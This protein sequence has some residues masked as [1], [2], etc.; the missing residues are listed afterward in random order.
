MRSKPKPGAKPAGA[1][2]WFRVYKLLERDF[3]RVAA[4]RRICSYVLALF[5]P[6]GQE[7]QPPLRENRGVASVF[8]GLVLLD[9]VFAP[10]RLR[11]TRATRVAW[12]L[13]RRIRQPTSREEQ[14]RVRLRDACVRSARGVRTDG[15]GGP[16]SV[17]TA[18]A[19]PPP[20][21]RIARNA[22]VAGRP[23]ELVLVVSGLFVSK[24]SALAFE[25]AWQRPHA[26]RHVARDWN[27]C[28]CGRSKSVRARLEALCLL[29]RHG[30]WVREVLACACCGL[31]SHHAWRRGRMCC[32]ACVTL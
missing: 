19:P 7:V 27:A 4:S 11:P 2:Y 8:A 20:A 13:S 14:E 17:A 28:G 1:G 25:S 24:S 29:L 6:L 16:A 3:I 5:T 12:R 9:H 23:W 10:R 15:R 26:S 32:S 22:P 21:Q 30:V 18:T 31:C